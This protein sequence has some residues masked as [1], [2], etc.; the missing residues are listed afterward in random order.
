MLRNHK[1]VTGVVIIVLIAAG[2]AAYLV[3]ANY[4]ENT[5][6]ETPAKKS[7]SPSSHKPIIKD[8]ST[9]KPGDK[10]PAVAPQEQ[11]IPAT[12]PSTGPTPKAAP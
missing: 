5:A 7:D 11:P 12:G 4:H 10:G 3:F 8:P 6:T 1:K 9:V 2:I